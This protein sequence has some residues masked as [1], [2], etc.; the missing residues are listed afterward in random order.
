MN[1]NQ[2]AQKD[3][4]TPEEIAKDDFQ[5]DL[6]DMQAVYMKIAELVGSS[7]SAMRANKLNEL[8]L[9]YQKDN[10]SRQKYRKAA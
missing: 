2:F 4:R 8:W 6:S 3:H 7:R 10:N 1:K 5:V 9:E